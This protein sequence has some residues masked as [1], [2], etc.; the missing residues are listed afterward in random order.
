MRHESEL[1]RN[2]MVRLQIMADDLQFSVLENPGAI[3]VSRFSVGPISSLRGILRH[4]PVAAPEL[5]A[6]IAEVE[7]LI[8]PVIR[9][10]PSGSVL[11]VEGREL[12]EAMEA[13]PASGAEP[14]TIEAVENLFGRLANVAMGSPAGSQGVPVT[15]SFVLGL[16]VL[17]EVMHHAGLHLVMLF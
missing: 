17:R 8:M 16:V 12:R 7:D 1:G 11:E 15:A 4:E 14:A 2:G 9:K 5:E 3:E 6:A 13:L 10:L